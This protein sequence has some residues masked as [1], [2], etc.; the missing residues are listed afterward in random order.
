MGRL[1]G[2][3]ALITGA[4]RGIGRAV[5]RVLAREGADIA[6]AELDPETTAE[7]VREIEGLG[8]RAIAIPGDIGL[9]EICEEAVR[10]TVAELGRLDILIN[11]A[12]LTAGMKPFEQ[13]TDEEFLRTYAVNALATFRLMRAASPH[14]R[15]SP[16]GRVINF[17]SGAGARGDFNQFDYAAAKES[18]RAMTRVAA[19]EFGPDGVTVNTVCPFA[20]SE[21]VQQH[22]DAKMIEMMRRTVPLGRIGDPES[23]IA[24]AVL[25][26]ASDDSAYVT[27]HTLWVDGGAGSVRS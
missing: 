21:G 11:N 22:L 24:R 3:V 13:F 15:R 6:V 19:R 18:V 20:N 10:R 8:R 26:L 25:F 16:A 1:D 23:D 2:R 27:A 7:A 9:A 17:S 14:L 5:A 12:A 4:G